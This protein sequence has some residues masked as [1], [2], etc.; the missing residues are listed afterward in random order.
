MVLGD[1]KFAP[2]GAQVTCG[3]KDLTVATH[4]THAL[5]P[6]SLLLLDIDLYSFTPTYFGDMG[7]GGGAGGFGCDRLCTH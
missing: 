7:G 2:R 6:D 1:Y 4:K 3:A 5:I